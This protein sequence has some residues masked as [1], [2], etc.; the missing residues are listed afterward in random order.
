MVN[1]VVSDKMNAYDKYGSY[2]PIQDRGADIVVK[3]RKGI[4]YSYF[5]QQYS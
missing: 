4:S 5:L 3:V 1:M 2:E